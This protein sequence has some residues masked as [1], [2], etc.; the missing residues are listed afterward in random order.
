MADIAASATLR[1]RAG[2]MAP[3]RTGAPGAV[4]ITFEDER[5]SGRRIR[6]HD[7]LVIGPNWSTIDCLTSAFAS[8]Q[9]RQHNPIVHPS[10]ISLRFFITCLRNR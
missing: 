2:A 7:G 8:G 10:T 1:L 9:S 6:A 4:P 5:Y 3:G